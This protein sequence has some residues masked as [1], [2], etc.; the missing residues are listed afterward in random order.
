MI[1]NTSMGKET[2]KNGLLNDGDNLSF[3]NMMKLWKEADKFDTDGYG[4][5][6]LTLISEFYNKLRLIKD[7]SLLK[8]I[9]AI[10]HPWKYK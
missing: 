8:K 9:D 2:N 5:L 10:I 7:E 6:S 1:N 3:E 4:D